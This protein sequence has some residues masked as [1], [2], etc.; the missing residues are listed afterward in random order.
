MATITPGFR[1]LARIGSNKV[2]FNSCTLNAVQEVEAPDLVM[3]DDTHDAWAYG[4]IEVAGAISGPVTEST[5]AFINA[6]DQATGVSGGGLGAEI[7]V[8]YYA[9][10]DRRFGGCELNSF[11]FT[12]TAGEVVTF[13]LDIIGETVDTDPYGATSGTTVASNTTFTKGEKLVTWDKAVLRVSGLKEDDSFTFADVAQ[14]SGLQSFTF[15]ASNNI[16]RQFII[17]ESSLFGDLVEGMKA[18]TGSVVSYIEQSSGN[19]EGVNGPFGDGEA[20][21]AGADFW[22]AYNGDEAN[23]FE[24]DIGSNLKIRSAVRFHRGTTELGVGPVVTTINFTGVTT[25]GFANLITA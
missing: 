24:F 25:F 9:G 20:T 22:D 16:T 23:P 2:R 12:I 10:F 11:S 15:N 14:L 18:V 1:G 21:P 6:L 17:S 8:H 13:N 3:G 19:V 4:K 7:D 5:G